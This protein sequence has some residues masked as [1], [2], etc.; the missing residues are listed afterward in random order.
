MDEEEEEEEEVLDYD[1]SSVLKY[2]MSTASSSNSSPSSSLPTQKPSNLFSSFAYN[3]HPSDPGVSLD[4]EATYSMHFHPTYDG[5]LVVGGKGGIVSLLS[6]PRGGKTNSSL[7]MS[8]KCHDRW[9]STTK[10]LSNTTGLYMV[11]ASDDGF[12]KVWDVSKSSKGTSVNKPKI[13]SSNG[14]TH[15]RRGV[16]SFDECGG[17]IVSG[18]K[19]R[20]VC[21]SRLQDDMTITGV[22]SYE[23]CHS[24]VVKSVSWQYEGE[25]VESKVPPHVFVSGGQD[26]LICLKDIRV[27]C[28]EFITLFRYNNT[29]VHHVE[30]NN[31]GGGDAANLFVVAGLDPVVKVFDIRMLSGSK[32]EPKHLYEF[33]G[34]AKSGLRSYKS[35]LAPKFM[36]EDVL[37]ALGEDSDFVSLYCLKTGRTLARGEMPEKP[38]AV[39]VNPCSQ[40]TVHVVTDAVEEDKSGDVSQDSGHRVTAHLA[41]AGRRSRQFY[42]LTL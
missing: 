41:I 21:I 17:W 25:G 32:E 18:S 29:G 40:A 2:V 35:M 9:V 7:L 22:T 27:P 4:L 11:T 24:G 28:S 13:L 42:S 38:M 20:N 16:Y 26:K 30:F 23:E 19:D 33:I 3:L 8:A 31:M 39:A 36:S 14:S 6:T 37:V 5:L 12:I 10:F 1:D 15:G 34:H